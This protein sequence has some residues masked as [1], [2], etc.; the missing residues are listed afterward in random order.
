[1]GR[2]DLRWLPFAPARIRS[3]RAFRP[4]RALLTLP[5]AP[6]ALLMLLRALPRAPGVEQLGAIHEA[7]LD[8][9]VARVDVTTLGLRGV[10]RAAPDVPLASLERL[11]AAPDTLVA[12]LQALTGR[13]TGCFCSVVPFTTPG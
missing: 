10:R 7:L 1:M 12:R 9:A 11:A 5:L 6:P 13:S 8:H 2:R 3:L 4:S